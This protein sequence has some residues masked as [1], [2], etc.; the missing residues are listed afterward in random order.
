MATAPKTELFATTFTQVPEKWGKVPPDNQDF[1]E[2][3]EA[4]I[5]MIHI[6]T[7]LRVAWHRG[8]EAALRKETEALAPYK[9]LP[10]VVREVKAVIV[11]RLKLFGGKA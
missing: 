3:M 9:L 2:A 6:N 5:A 8:L 11:E 4:G 7:E 1:R 10:A